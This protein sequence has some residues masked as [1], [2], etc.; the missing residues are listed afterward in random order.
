[1]AASVIWALR[2][3][4][5]WKRNGRKQKEKKEALEERKRGSAENGM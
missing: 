1:M 3:S 4:I 5:L 2:Y